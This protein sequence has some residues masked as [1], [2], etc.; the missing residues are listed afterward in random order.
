MIRSR[1]STV[2][3]IVNFQYVHKKLDYDLLDTFAVEAPMTRSKKNRGSLYGASSFESLDDYRHTAYKR[4]FGR[5][6]QSS[7]FQL[8][9]LPPTSAAAKQHPYRTYLT[10]IMY[11]TL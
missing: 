6:S 1:Q 2:R 11:K 7:S 9:S 3:A 5:S 4:A 8:E 10:V